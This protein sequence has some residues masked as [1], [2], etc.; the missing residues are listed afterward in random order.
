MYGPMGDE[1]KFS[2]FQLGYCALLFYY[3]FWHEVHR[4][5]NIHNILRIVI[6]GKPVAKNAKIEHNL[7]KESNVHA[8]SFLSR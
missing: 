1:Y 5:V 8:T 6:F 7:V 4:L 3:V 2:G